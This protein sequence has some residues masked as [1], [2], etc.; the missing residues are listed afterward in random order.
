MDILKVYAQLEIDEGRR[1][2]VYMDTTGNP[3]CGIGHKLVGT[4]LA[5]YPVGSTVP[6]EVIEQWFQQDVARAIEAA[7]KAPG[8]PFYGQPDGVQDS[9][10]NM[11]YNMGPGGVEG[12]PH[13]LTCLKAH[14][15][16]GAARELETSFWAK[17]V[18]DRATRII[19]I[20]L[21][22]RTTI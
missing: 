19:A 11:V 9:L 20:I 5:D 16:I 1:S 15:Y 10:I 2:V 14:D 7:E 21:S 8:I 22:A 6:D 12:F 3:T 18:G 17:Q 4:E 13:F